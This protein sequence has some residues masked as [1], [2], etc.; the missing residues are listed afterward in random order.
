MNDVNSSILSNNAELVSEILTIISL[1]DVG[2]QFYISGINQNPDISIAL[3]K[4]IKE[5]LEAL[6]VSIDKGA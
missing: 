4:V 3:F 1:A 5:R 6:I 2:Y